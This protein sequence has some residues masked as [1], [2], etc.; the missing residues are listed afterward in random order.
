MT[1]KWHALF[2]ILHYNHLPMLIVNF[3]LSQADLKEST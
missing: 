1:R 2:K 3:E